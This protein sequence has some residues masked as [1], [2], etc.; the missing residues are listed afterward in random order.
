MLL[1]EDRDM[2]SDT[3][4]HATVK[5]GAKGGSAKAPIPKRPSTTPPRPR[6]GS[7][8]QKL[9]DAR[10]GIKT[11]GSI[12]GSRSIV[13]RGASVH[14][15]PMEMMSHKLDEADEYTRRI[16]QQKRD[17]T[18]NERM[19]KEY[20][21]KMLQIQ[22]AISSYLSDKTMRDKA[23]GAAAVHRWENKLNTSS[24]KHSKA[25]SIIANIKEQINN[26]RL[27]QVE[28]KK[29]WKKINEDFVNAH[30]IIVEHEGRIKDAKAAK[31]MAEKRTK[32]V[33]LEAEQEAV[34]FKKKLQELTVRFIYDLIDLIFDDLKLFA[35]HAP[36]YYRLAYRRSVTHKGLE[37]GQRGRSEGS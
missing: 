17:M 14:M 8:R 29:Q 22:K 24:I 37:E 34:A 19:I 1:S 21:V 10:G 13:S 4:L 16:Q 6:P 36:G 7:R 31:I 26:A 23:G 25:K 20:K 30:A 18:R 32:Q 28:H 15:T 3:G 9:D 5:S 33:Q 11:R 27:A 2:K 35:C 12:R